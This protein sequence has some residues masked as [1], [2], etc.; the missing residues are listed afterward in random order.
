MFYICYYVALFIMEKIVCKIPIKSK[1]WWQF[2][3]KSDKKRAL[4]LMKQYKENIVIKN[5]DDE[6]EFFIPTNAT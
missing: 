2:W 1:K 4:E 6:S 3:K 5:G